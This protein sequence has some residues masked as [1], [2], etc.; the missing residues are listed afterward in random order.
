MGKW[1]ILRL[2]ACAHQRVANNDRCKT[3][4]IIII[5]TLL[6]HSNNG[7]KCDDNKINK[8]YIE[9]CRLFGCFIFYCAIAP[10]GC[11]LHSAVEIIGR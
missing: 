5:N 1:N 6:L 2:T 7:Y 4:N 8:K 3:G 11:L 9:W 10:G